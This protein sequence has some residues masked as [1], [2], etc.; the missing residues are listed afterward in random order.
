[1]QAKVP[2]SQGISDPISPALM[3]HKTVHEHPDHEKHPL[4][5]PEWRV[6]SGECGE[7]VR[8]CWSQVLVP[9]QWR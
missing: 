8:D 5:L 3:S 9:R 2:T 6:D 4:P 1:M 7:G